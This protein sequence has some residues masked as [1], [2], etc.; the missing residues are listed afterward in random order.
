MWQRQYPQR[1]NFGAINMNTITS[2]YTAVTAF[3]YCPPFVAP[4]KS[5]HPKNSKRM[6]SPLEQIKKKPGK[7]HIQQQMETHAKK[8]T[9][10][11]RTKISGGK[12]GRKGIVVTDCE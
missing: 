6:Q 8:V 5:G 1:D 11:T 7:V 9:K 2:N 10:T 4:K 12:R 3:R